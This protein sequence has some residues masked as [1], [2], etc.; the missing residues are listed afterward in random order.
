MPS[1]SVSDP[2][3]EPVE[4]GIS[5]GSITDP[6]ETQHVHA[7]LT[8]TSTGHEDLRELESGLDSLQSDADRKH[9]LEARERF[10]EYLRSINA[11]H[12]RPR[13]YNALTTNCTT[14]IR[15]QHTVSDRIPWDWRILVNGKADEMLYERKRIATAGLSFADLRR[16]GR[17]NE[18]ARAANDDPEFSKRIREGV[19]G[20]GPDDSTPLAR[21][22]RFT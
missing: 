11:L 16:R 13:W 21:Y 8:R 9:L 15:E 19:P 1:N 7:A 3:V 2:V 17:I 6:A 22:S 14:A 20:F 5:T 4:T 10:L 12:A 18:L